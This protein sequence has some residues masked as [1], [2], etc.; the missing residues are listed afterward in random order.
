[1]PRYGVAN[2]DEESRGD[3]RRIEMR[4]E[5]VADCW[6]MIPSERTRRNVSRTTRAHRLLVLLGLSSGVLLHV[7]NTALKP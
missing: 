1:M 7:M 6:R 2:G 5:G 3:G 4:W